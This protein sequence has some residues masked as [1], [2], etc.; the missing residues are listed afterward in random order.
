MTF[1]H[2][3]AFFFIYFGWGSLYFA[4]RVAVQTIPPFLLAGSSS[5]LS[6][7]AL[8]ALSGSQRPSWSEW[9]AAVLPSF[10][11]VMLGNGAVVWAEQHLNSAVTALI[12]ASEPV[13]FILLDAFIFKATKPGPKVWGG[14][15]F[16][17]AGIAILLFDLITDGC[18]DI[19][20]LNGD[21][22]PY[23]LVLTAAMGWSLG[24]LLCR[25]DRLPKN[26][27]MAIALPVFI[28]GWG[29]LVISLLS[30]EWGQFEW[31]RVSLSSVWAYGYM[32]LVCYAATYKSYIWLL[33]NVPIS[34]VTTYAYIN[35]LVA[36]GLGFFWDKAVLRP[37]FW[38]GGAVILVGVFLI[39]HK[40][41]YTA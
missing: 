20:P 7:L 13:W 33:K 23:L 18:P 32:V 1:S 16:G 29:L 4:I 5:V 38:V 27:T 11:M 19:C 39:L 17:L 40:K 25:S 36:V 37:E 34:Q 31:S 41:E 10:F 15:F 28:G 24:S 35:P 6:A 12:L 8:M 2:A 22:R 30:G 3:A 26:P 9:K 14:I 21:L